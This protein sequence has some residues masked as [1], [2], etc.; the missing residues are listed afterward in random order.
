[1]IENMTQNILPSVKEFPDVIKTRTIIVAITKFAIFT[2][3]VNLHLLLSIVLFF[4]LDQPRS[5]WERGWMENFW[6]SMEI[7]SSSYR[8]I[9]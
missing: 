7:F 6:W 4:L 1:M 5:I 3:D 2:T 9:S 8:F